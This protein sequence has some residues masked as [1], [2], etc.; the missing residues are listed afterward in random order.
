M[1]SSP[2]WL[3]VAIAVEVPIASR[4][5]KLVVSFGNHRDSVFLAVETHKF[6]M[7][8]KHQLFNQPPKK[9]LF[10]FHKHHVFSWDM[11]FLQAL[12][13]LG[14]SALRKS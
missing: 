5:C 1:R 8:I 12:D 3:P 7:P 4:T 6:V 14:S 10:F 2:V 9:N 13:A 11:T